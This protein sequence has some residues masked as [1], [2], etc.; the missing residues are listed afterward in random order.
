MAQIH[1]TSVVD[2][3]AVL[4]R[5]VVI[6][7]Y[8]VV[9]AGAVIG[10]DCHL[11]ARCSVKSLTTLGCNNQIGEGAV[12]GGMA[13]HVQVHEPGGH[14]TI[15]N[16]NRIREDV[17][18]HRGWMNEATTAIGDDNL[19]MG[20]SH[21]AHDCRVGNHCTLVNRVLLGG[22][23]QVD[24]GAFLG[25]GSAVAQNCRIGRLAMVGATTKVTQDVP[26]YVTYSGS[27]VLGLNNF[28]LRRGSY[29]AEQLG[30][31]EEAYRVIYRQGLTWNE[32][33]A[34]LKSE[35]LSGPAADFNDFLA[36]GKRGFVQERRIARDPDLELV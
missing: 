13:Q 16:H 19:L 12:I 32:V 17:T 33:L 27:E 21:V 8:C 23:V 14:L 24:D 36:T 4:G 28:G 26:P 34:T 11:E 3:S 35:F 20:G 6:G 29:S 18:I 1:R 30:R 31:L 15:G 22:F 25:R 9:E 2:A 7:P 5:N 10:D